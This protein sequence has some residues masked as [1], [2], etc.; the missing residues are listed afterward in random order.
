MERKSSGGRSNGE[1]ASS[2]RSFWGGRLLLAAFFAVAGAAGAHAETY[3]LDNGGKYNS[4]PYPNPLTNAYCWIAADGVTRAGDSGEAIP[5]DG[6]FYLRGAGAKAG[7][8]GVV[9]LRSAA[10]TYTFKELHIGDVANSREGRLLQYVKSLI[11]LN[12]MTY[13]EKGRFVCNLGD[14]GS[15]SVDS[16]FMVTAPKSAPFIMAA[17]YTGSEMVLKGTMSAEEGACLQI[18]GNNGYQGND[19][20][21]SIY[22]FDLDFSEY[23]GVLRLYNDDKTVRTGDVIP[24][25]FCFK[26]SAT[27]AG[28]VKAD[29]DILVEFPVPGTSVQ[30]ANMSLGN[31]SMLRFHSNDSG[32][33]KLTVTGAFSREGKINVDLAFD[34]WENPG[35]HSRTLLTVPVANAFTMDDINCGTSAEKP[36]ECEFSVATDEGAGTC[37][38]VCTYCFVPE[39]WVYLKTGDVVNKDNNTAA[40]MNSS[41]TNASHWSDGSVPE[42]G[43][44]YILRSVEGSSVTLRTLQNGWTDGAGQSAADYRF[45][46]ES[47][48]IFGQTMVLCSGKISFKKLDLYDGTVIIGANANPDVKAIG[49]TVELHPGVIHLRENVGNRTIFDGTVIGTG[50]FCLDGVSP[51]SNPSG[52]YSFSK[53]DM[54]NF[55]G[56]IR[57]SNNRNNEKPDFWKTNQVLLVSA[58]KQLGGRLDEFDP[59]ALVLER[60]GTLRATESFTITTDKNRGITVN[61]SGRFYVD[62]GVTLGIATPIAASGLLRKSHPGT[63]RLASVMTVDGGDDVEDILELHGGTLCLDHADAINGMTLAVSNGTS[64]VVQ[65]DLSDPDRKAYGVRMEKAAVPFVLPEGTESL[66]LTLIAAGGLPEDE[67]VT[68]CGMFTVVNDPAVVAAVRAMLP[69]AF[70]QVFPRRMQELVEIEDPEKGTLTFALK[71]IRRGMT[72]VVR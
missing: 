21:R 69:K 52:V 40:S 15:Y 56:R 64:V 46:G 67:M 16:S 47:L 37:S 44:N 68:T 38:L 59:K 8:E 12:G 2:R 30:V 11:V 71:L 27:I 63:L 57:I 1:P 36:L 29:H 10:A 58:A 4:N 7:T 14:G 18:G 31:N 65:M 3:W 53:A 72:V 32:A 20:D 66:P 17:G 13:L 24:Q 62:S 42:A 50:E 70:A 41:L 54:S 33:S 34:G 61:G 6:I 55:K 45:Q 48:S 60:C 9:R 5:S 35:T 22:T 51:G 39:G 28:T 49:G 19:P 23:R 25:R 26:K 43:K